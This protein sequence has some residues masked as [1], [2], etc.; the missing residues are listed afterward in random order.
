MSVVEIPQSV[1][2]NAVSEK[3]TEEPTEENDPFD[4]N[5]RRNVT[6]NLVIK[7]GSTVVYKDYIS[8]D[9][10][11][12]NAIEMFCAEQFEEEITCFDEN[13]ILRTIGELTA[14]DGKRW[15]A[16]YEDEGQ[17]KAFESIKTQQLF[18]GKTV[19][20]CLD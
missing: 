11:L 2:D 5:D 13:G 16:W 9:G 8:C 20:I 14:S 3:G 7:D 18:D 12:G 15:R 4:D 6:V 19:V 10:T 1:I 17:S